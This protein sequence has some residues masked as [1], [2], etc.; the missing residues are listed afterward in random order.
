[1]LDKSIEDIYDPEDHIDPINILCQ[2]DN[3]FYEKLESKKWQERKEGIDKLEGILA[4]SLKLENGD[5]RDL[6]R[7][8]KTV[9]SYILSF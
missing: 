8:L 3:N 9:R 2:L 1:M 5:Y 4:N 7:A 6:V